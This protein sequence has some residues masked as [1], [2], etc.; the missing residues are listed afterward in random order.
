MG[1][2][3]VNRNTGK[4]SGSTSRSSKM[5]LCLHYGICVLRLKVKCLSIPVKVEYSCP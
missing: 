2:D 1:L 5:L 3:F 4:F